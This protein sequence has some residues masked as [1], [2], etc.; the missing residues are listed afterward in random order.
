M[1]PQQRRVEQSREEA[2]PLPRDPQLGTESNLIVYVPVH[3]VEILAGL[4]IINS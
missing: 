1:H 4:L 2:S 3:W